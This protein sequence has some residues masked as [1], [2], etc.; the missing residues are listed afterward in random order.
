MISTL[1][2]SLLLTYTSTSSG[3][4]YEERRPVAL[5][6]I[7]DPAVMRY[8]RDTAKVETEASLAVRALRVL[9][10]QVAFELGRN[11][12][13][14]VEDTDLHRLWVGRIQPNCSDLDLAVDVAV[15]DRVSDQVVEHAFDESHFEPPC[16]IWLTL[17]PDADAAVHGVNFDHAVEESLHVVERAM[18]FDRRVLEPRDVDEVRDETRHPAQGIAGRG[19]RLRLIRIEAGRGGLEEVHVAQRDREAVVEVVCEHRRGFGAVGEEP[20]GT[21]PSDAGFDER[22]LG[23]RGG[24]HAAVKLRNRDRLGDHVIRTGIEARAPHLVG[25]VAREHRDPHRGAVELLETLDDQD[26]GSGH[27]EVDDREI[28]RGGLDL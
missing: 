1:I 23:T 19:Q 6:T 12:G 13:P 22:A 4:P 15:A 14:V 26:A 11:R 9:A 25:V 7:H 27:L 3:Q 17:D 24:D 20:I 18:R 10:V 28:R 2:G 5:P 8:A 16:K 21:L